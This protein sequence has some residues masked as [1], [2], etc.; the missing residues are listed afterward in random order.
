MPAAEF[1]LSDAEADVLFADLADARALLLAVS[2]GPDSTALLALAARWRKRLGRGPALIAVTIDHGLRPEAR[3]EAAAVKRLARR[4]GVPHRT[5][6]W[7]HSGPRT[8]IQEKAR[9]ARYDL[10]R[11][12][13]RRHGARHVLTAHTLDDQAETILFRMARGSGISGLAGM[14]RASAQVDDMILVRPFLRVPKARLLAT[15]AAKSLPFIDDPSNRDP[16]FARSRLRPLIARL[17]QEGLDTQRLS[18]LAL[19]MRRA[20][21]AI[22]AVVD[23]AARFA[24][25]PGAPRAGIVIDAPKFG[26]L[27]AEVALR[28]L[29][30]AIARVGDEGPVELGKLEALMAALAESG[31][32]RFRRTLAGAMITLARDQLV[33]ERAPARKKR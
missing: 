12:E 16:R 26:S 9:E 27:P 30:R 21:A 3:R 25:R 29:G 20:D 10:L 32:G 4:L 15:L 28:L 1:P 33:V 23:A 11:R 7:V 13:A 2:G 14:T 24:A 22:E 6:R 18:L 5:L 8:G 19:R 17:A 31:D